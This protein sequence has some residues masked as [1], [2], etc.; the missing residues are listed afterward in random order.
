MVYNQI[1]LI[2]K[3]LFCLGVHYYPKHI[4]LH[5]CAAVLVKMCSVLISMINRADFKRVI[6]SSLPLT[7]L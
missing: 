4:Y 5:K 7:L 2:L 6:V 3:E 1:R